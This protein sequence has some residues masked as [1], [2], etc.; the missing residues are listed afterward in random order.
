MTGEPADDAALAAFEPHRG[1]LFAVAY[2]MLGSVAEAE[3]VVQDAYL[4]WSRADRSTV[5]VPRAY[6]TRAVTRLCLD[7]RSSA[8][9]RREEYPGTWLPEPLVESDPQAPHALADDL[10]MALLVALERLSPLERAAFLLHDVFDLE[11]AEVASALERT[12]EAVRQLAA[13]ARAHVRDTRPRYQPSAAEASRLSAA[14]GAAILN[15]DVDGLR[16][17]LAEDAILYSDGGGKRSAALNPIYGSDKIA[18]F[19]E[20]VTRKKGLQTDP[21]KARFAWI[22]GLPGF[23]VQSPD[24]IETLALEIEGDRVVTI[25]IVRNPDKLRHLTSG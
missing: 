14:F 24:G 13:R 16:R 6:L 4:R 2:R 18:R 21:S 17:L 7:R 9:A 3:D 5:D 15:G 22:N 10:S 19:V 25:Y 1:H 12:E 8:A 20:G 11:F 23:V